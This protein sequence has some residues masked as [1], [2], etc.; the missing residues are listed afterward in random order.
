LQQAHTTI[1]ELSTGEQLGCSEPMTRH[2]WKICV[3]LFAA[4]TLNYIDR[5]VL[6][7]LKP[8]LE[9]P[10]IGI[11]LTEVEYAAIVSIFSAAY[12]IGLLVAGRFVDRVGT[13]IGYAVA[14]SFWTLASISHYFAG[15]HAVTGALHNS[16]AM[17]G[18]L[19]QHLPGVSSGHWVEVM[20]NLSGAVICLAIARFALGLG[21][22][23]NFPAAIK[24][25]A[26]WFPRKERALATG[27]F[28]SGT[29]IGATLAPFITGLI[30][31]RLGWRFTFLT[32]SVFAI[33]W[34]NLWLTMY[35]CPGEVR[36]VSPA[37]LAYI[38]QDTLPQ[39]EIK[40]AWSRLTRFRQTWAFLLGKVLTD[41]VWWF[42][43]YWLPGML[44]ARFGLTLMSM[45]LPLLTVYSSCTIGSLV[46]GWLPARLVAR[47]WTVNRSRKSAMLLYALFMTPI[48]LIG[49]TQ[50]LWGAVA[51]ISLATS[52]HQAWS[53]NLFTLVS[54]MFPQRAVASVVGIGAC[55]GSFSMMFVGLL[56]GLILTLT[57]GDYAPLFVMAGTV[58]LFA[59]AVIHLIVPKLQSVPI[60]E[61]GSIQSTTCP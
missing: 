26:E 42:Y 24:A 25:V 1:A 19:L 22:A 52:A 29:N 55:G 21:Q 3:L 54:D 8:V 51:L 41:P 6:A 32:T 34:L 36:G 14:L 11:G 15:T 58:Y 18:R 9:D 60:Q 45:G 50:S 47:G 35:R 48:M 23:G 37:E 57:H 4:T 38:N 49:R 43:L 13:R 10:R 17:L 59:I 46:G 40:I 20:E 56:I 30:L 53:A 27:V 16:M 39:V 7:L 2:R 12:A 31:Y 61:L 44:H 5:Q 28:N 33:I